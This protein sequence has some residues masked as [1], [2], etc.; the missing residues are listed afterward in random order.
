MAKDLF[1]K[2]RLITASNGHVPSARRRSRAASHSRI[3][4]IVPI[5]IWPDIGASSSARLTNEQRLKIRQPNMVRP[6]IPADPDRVRTPVRAI[7]QDAA[8]ARRSHFP[9]GD[10]LLMCEL[11]MAI[12]ARPS[13]CA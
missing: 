9:K 6:S 13:I 4:A 5:P 8:N 11:G 1:S 3:V 2:P 7:N 12:E 10:F